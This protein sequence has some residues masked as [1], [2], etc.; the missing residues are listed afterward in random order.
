MPDIPCEWLQY[1]SADHL[2]CSCFGSP[3]WRQVVSHQEIDG[4]ATMVVTAN[5]RVFG[6]IPEFLILR[7]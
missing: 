2:T 4:T 1:V 7:I 3:A 5:D 6:I